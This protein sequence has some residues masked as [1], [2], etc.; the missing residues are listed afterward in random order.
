MRLPGTESFTILLAAC[1]YEGV[2]GCNV[3][4]SILHASSR[5][6]GKLQALIALRAYSEDVP[7]ASSQGHHVQHIRGSDRLSL[8]CTCLLLLLLLLPAGDLVVY[9]V[10]LANRG[11]VHLK[12]VDLHP[13][14]NSSSSGMN[15][16]FPMDCGTGGVLPMQISVAGTLTCTR[17]IEFTTPVS[18][19]ITEVG[20]VLETGG[21]HANSAS[22]DCSRNGTVKQDH[23]LWHTGLPDSSA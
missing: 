1:T 12:S 5:L 6:L 11:N 8:T 19:I 16:T 3:C 15:T 22:H 13:V 17:T 18:S 2:T 20:S 14:T 23:Q 21:L 7:A 9:T 4:R 10:Q